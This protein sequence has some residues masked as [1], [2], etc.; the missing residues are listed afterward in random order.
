MVSE[1]LRFQ[2]TVSGWSRF[3]DVRVENGK[4]SMEIARVNCSHCATCR[5]RVEHVEAALQGQAYAREF[6]GGG[7]YY[8]LNLPDECSGDIRKVTEFLG[9]TLRLDIRSAS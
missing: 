9:R 5:R 4:V 3:R 1:A 7:I 8:S 2:T 6:V